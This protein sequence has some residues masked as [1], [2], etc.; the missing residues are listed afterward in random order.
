[1]KT[2][3]V[4]PEQA[5]EYWPTLG[6]MLKDSLDHGVGESSLTD[7]MRKILCYET[8]LWAFM[9][10]DNKLKGTGLTKF[11]Q[12]EN[13]KTLHII[14]CSGVDWDEWAEQYYVVEQFAKDNGCKAVEQWGRKGWSRILPKVI[15][16]FQV[17]Y[18]VMRKEIQG[19]LNVI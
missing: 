4:K 19:D 2:I 18:H 10:D 9:D 5:L 1:M 8:Q 6:P 17:V 15:P 14:A 7:Y 13:H 16:G 3:L 12:Y 11:I